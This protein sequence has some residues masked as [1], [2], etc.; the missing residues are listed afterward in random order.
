MK[1]AGNLM[2]YGKTKYEENNKNK[3][4]SRYPA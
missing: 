4:R 2:H 1:L 3:E